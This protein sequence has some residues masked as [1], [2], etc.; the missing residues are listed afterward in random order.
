MAEKR[1]LVFPLFRH[2]SFDPAKVK[3]ID[4]KNTDNEFEKEILIDYLLSAH[5]QVDSNLNIIIK[6][7]E[8]L[9]ENNRLKEKADIFMGDVANSRIM[10]FYESSF[11]TKASE[12]SLEETLRNGPSDTDKNWDYAMQNSVSNTVN[13][14]NELEYLGMPPDELV[15]RFKISP[16]NSVTTDEYLEILK[17]S[18][19]FLTLYKNMLGKKIAEN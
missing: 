18:R 8:E 3:E 7:E 1:I 15:K 16:E 17:S 5:A 11:A 19:D 6:K 9:E 13:F 10:G 4:L 2:F 12:A 14:L